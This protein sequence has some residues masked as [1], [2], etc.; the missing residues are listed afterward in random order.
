M[1]PEIDMERDT[2]IIGYFAAT[3]RGDVVCDG[4][5][6]IIAG[7]YKTMKD[8]LAKSKTKPPG[9]IRIVKTRFGEILAGMRMG[10][11]Y[12]FD[13]ESYG[14]FLPLARETG[15]NL[16]DAD[17]TP[18]KAGDVRFLTITPTGASQGDPGRYPNPSNG[19]TT[20]SLF[21]PVATCR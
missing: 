4:P 16:D 3:N 15:M 7:S 17:F 6:C 14:R 13:A 21:A 18:E 2:I 1:G 5:A 9:T 10:A 8:Y 19:L 12:S 20:P 11:A